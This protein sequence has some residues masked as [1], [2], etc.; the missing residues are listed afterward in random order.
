MYYDDT[1]SNEYSPDLQLDLIFL[2][3]RLSNLM[4]VINSNERVCQDDTKPVIQF[5]KQAKRYTNTTTSFTFNLDVCDEG[6]FNTMDAYIY[7]TRA[8]PREDLAMQNIS[9]YF[10]RLIR[11]LDSSNVTETVTITFLRKLTDVIEVEKNK[12]VAVFS[13]CNL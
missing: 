12:A 10:E 9:D 11:N 5:L 4:K 1:L 7:S 6:N 3:Y 2:N 13:K 8:I